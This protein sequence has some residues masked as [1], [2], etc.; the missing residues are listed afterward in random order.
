M[1]VFSPLRSG[2][3]AE[4]QAV[5]VTGS[6]TDVAT[7]DTHVVTVDWATGSSPTR[8]CRKAPARVP[9]WASTPTR[10]AASIQS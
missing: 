3:V 6:F 4:G 1:S 8:K 5:I 10:P 9:S 7:L 2:P